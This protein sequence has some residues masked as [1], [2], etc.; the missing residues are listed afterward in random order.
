RS[1]DDRPLARTR[2]A[3][4]HPPLPRSRSRIKRARVEASRAI[5]VAGPPLQGRRVAARL[6]DQPLIMESARRRLARSPPTP[7]AIAYQIAALP[8]T[9]KFEPRLIAPLSASVITSPQRVEVHS[10]LERDRVRR[11]NR[12]APGRCVH[13]RA[14]GGIG[15]CDRRR[16]SSAV[17]FPHSLKRETRGQ[18]IEPNGLVTVTS[19]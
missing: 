5:G 6:P 1:R 9:R 17:S 3:G 10:T 14:C 15:T 18:G 13:R 7:S 2:A 16:R 11:A 19:A 12:G 4:D 8:I